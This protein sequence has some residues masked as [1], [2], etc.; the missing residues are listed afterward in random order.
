MRST[1]AALA[2]ALALA[3]CVQVVQAPPQPP[4]APK[5]TTF[6]GEG[7]PHLVPTDAPGLFAAPSLGPTVYYYEP[8]EYWCRYAKNRWYTAFTWDGNWFDLPERNV[9]AVLAKRHK[10]PPPKKV[11]EELAELERQLKELE[12][13]PD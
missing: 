8:E 4:D 10:P 2:A 3:A 6:E 7:P 1:F 13:G 5:L 12:R 9:P 11:E